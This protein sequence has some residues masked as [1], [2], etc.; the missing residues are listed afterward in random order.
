MK[1]AMILTLSLFIAAA[2]S[3]SLAATTKC[4][5]T[6]VN[7]NSISLDCGIK[8]KAFKIGDEVKVRAAKKEKAIEG[9]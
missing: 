3:N 2:A 4:T 7:D 1:R 8:A 6:A 9:C 5:V